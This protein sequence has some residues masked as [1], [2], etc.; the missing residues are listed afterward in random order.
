MVLVVFANRTPREAVADAIAD[1]S[2]ANIMGI[3]LNHFDSTS[4]YYRRY[5]YKYNYGYGYGYGYG[6]SYGYGSSR[7]K[8]YAPEVKQTKE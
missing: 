2:G 6:Q 5:K 7:K 1:L 3:V 4:R 8:G